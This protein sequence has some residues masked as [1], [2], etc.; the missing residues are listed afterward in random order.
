MLTASI[1]LQLIAAAVTPVVL[2]SAA[3]ILISGINQ[4]HQSL[5]DRVRSLAAEVRAGG[6]SGMRQ[7]SIHAQMDIFRQRLEYVAAAHRLLHVSVTCFLLMV[8][9]ITLEARVR[10]WDRLALGLLVVGVALMLIAVGLELFDL[11][12][13]LQTL[14][15]DVEDV[16]EP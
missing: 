12:R 5:S 14:K 1:I 7:A 10:L 15:L 16:V 3:A 6:V 2:I 4:K 11:S 13:A 9:A 8:L